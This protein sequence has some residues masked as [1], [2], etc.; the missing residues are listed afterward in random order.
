M[1][2]LT[3]D[4]EDWFHILANPET[5]TV[6]QWGNFESRLNKNVDRILELL[7]AHNYPATFFCLGWVAKNFPDI[8]RR[9]DAMGYEVASHSNLHQLV[10]EQSPNEFR[11]DLIES[12][13]R[14]ED[15]IGK[16]VVTYRAP[17]F[18]LIR[19][20][21]WA[22]ETL[23]EMGIERDSSIFPTTR[24][25]GGYSAFGSA[26]PSLLSCKGGFIKEF[27][28]NTAKILGS[29]FVFSGG[30]YFR[31][32]PYSIIQHLTLR[33][34]YV[35]TYFHPRDF[36]PGQPN[37]NLS[38]LRS[39]KSYVGLNTSFAKFDKWLRANDF[40]S[41]DQADEQIDW[42]SAPIIKID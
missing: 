15:V 33:S 38:R 35:M 32:L 37:L 41:L 5:A 34:D 30:G 23:L 21:P 29:E 1:N 8:V 42:K 4:I 18:S 13:N 36:D 12:M 16:K 27:P 7:D 19:G 10:F 39:F 22:F 14:I 31:L 24:A 3:F 25:H 26:E 6:S 2:I 40:V 20:N 28:I 9:I 17:G 11:N